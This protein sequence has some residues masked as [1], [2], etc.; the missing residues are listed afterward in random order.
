MCSG[1]VCGGR[2]PRVV[3][4]SSPRVSQLACDRRPQDRCQ[5]AAARRHCRKA[6]WLGSVPRFR[7]YCTSVFPYT[8]RCGPPFAGG[9]A[10]VRMS[11]WPASAGICG[12]HGVFFVSSVGRACL[13]GSR[14]LVHD[15]ADAQSS[16]SFFFYRTARPVDACRGVRLG[17]GVTLVVPGFLF[18]CLPP[19]LE[20]RE[21][22]GS[23]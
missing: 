9:Q 16:W 23:C 15:V 5:P 6:A 4:A 21:L 11:S 18:T 8:S 20:W 3:P 2:S 7:T 14:V 22:L 10:R 19:R 1:V 13:A 17:G 12:R